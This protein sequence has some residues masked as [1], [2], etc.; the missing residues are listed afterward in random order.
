MTATI[1]TTRTAVRTVV[2]GRSP[3]EILDDVRM[4]I[5]TAVE[6][7]RPLQERF[8]KMFLSRFGT[9]PNLDSIMEDPN[10][11]RTRNALA[12]EIRYQAGLYLFWSNTAHETWMKAH[13]ALFH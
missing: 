8:P 13:H 12:C 11:I 1:T 3:E 6:I 5:L 9:L 10:P 4:A 7:L 2:Y